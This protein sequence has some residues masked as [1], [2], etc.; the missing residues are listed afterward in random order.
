MTGVINS[1]GIVVFKA[2]KVLVVKHG[3]AA[4][5]LTGIVG[6]PGG[7]IEKGETAKEAA[8]RELA[9]ETGLKAVAKSMIEL[10]TKYH[11]TI[12]SK[13]GPRTFYHRVFLVREYFGSLQANEKT[14]PEWVTLDKLKD[15]TLLPNVQDAV[16]EA[17]TGLSS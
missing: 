1:V 7:V 4:K 11:A 8:I 5:H 12:E 13:G 15:F 6:L 3:E 2:A 9:E 10:P 16:S 14:I 17:L